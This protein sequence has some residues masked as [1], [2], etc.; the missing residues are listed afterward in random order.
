MVEK[1]ALY[2]QHIARLISIRSKIFSKVAELSCEAALSKEPIPKEKL[3]NA[4]FVSFKKGS[5]WAS[6]FDCAWFKFKGKVPQTCKDK[7][8]VALINIQGEGLVERQSKASRRCLT[9]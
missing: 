9:E 5:V 2:P 7:K 4:Q 3:E 8:I 1:I 6:D